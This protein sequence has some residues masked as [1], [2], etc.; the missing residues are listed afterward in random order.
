VVYGI[1]PAVDLAR[2]VAA[3]TNSAVWLGLEPPL[4]S[5]HQAGR[6]RSDRDPPIFSVRLR[7]P[8][9]GLVLVDDVVTTGA[10]MTRAH[11]LIANE[12]PRARV[13]MAVSATS[14]RD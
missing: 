4:L 10:T 11:E 14:T 8:E 7:P 5:R 12:M 9:N 13:L 2:R 3:L 6:S 1:D